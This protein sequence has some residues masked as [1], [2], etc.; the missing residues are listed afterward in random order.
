MASGSGSYSP[1]DG[2]MVRQYG[3][4]NGRGSLGDRFRDPLVWVERFA[5]EVLVR[6]PTCAECA[7]VLDHL[8]VPECQASRGN[9][10]LVA[11][12]RLRCL[13]CGLTKDGFPSERVFGVPVDPYFR[14]PLWLQAD[15][16]GKLLWAYNAEHLDLLESYVAARLRERRASPGSMSMLARLPAWLKSAKNR[17][18]ILRDI[19]RLRLSLPTARQ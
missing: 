16:C 10:R 17:D 14:L 18:E 1:D 3:L 9:G 12:R 15:C 8:G 2:L 6:C 7:I 11:R 4:V 5:D 13:A 19:R